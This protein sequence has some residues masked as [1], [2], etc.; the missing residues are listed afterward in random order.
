MS[1]QG[2][3]SG[4]SLSDLVFQQ[5]W[6]ERRPKEAARHCL[7]ARVFL[8][9]E[10]KRP[11][12][13]SVQKSISAD[14]RL[15]FE[16]SRRCFSWCSWLRYILKVWL[17]WKKQVCGCQ[18]IEELRKRQSSGHKKGCA[19]W[20]NHFQL[21]GWRHKSRWRQLRKKVPEE[22]YSSAKVRFFPDLC[23]VWARFFSSSKYKSEEV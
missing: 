7:F 20:A 6:I 8:P 5:W 23:L 1:P 19:M 14:I 16:S 11:L 21:V 17:G 13:L 2:L 12:S 4:L 22:A 3:G 15:M 9:A 18:N 10:S